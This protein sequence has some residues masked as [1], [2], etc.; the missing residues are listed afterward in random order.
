MNVTYSEPNEYND[1]FPSYI[2]T[3]KQHTSIKTV[4]DLGCNVG[5]F[6]KLTKKL[7]PD[8]QKIVGFEPDIDNF[9]Y[10]KAQNYT[11]VELHNVGIYYGVEESRVCG[12]GDNNIGGYMVS[13]IDEEHVKNWGSSILTYEGRVF[14][15]KPLEHFT[16]NESLDLIKIDVEA[17]EYNILDN[18]TD[19]QKFKWIIL[20][21]HN[22]N[23]DYYINYIKNTLPYHE[24]VANTDYHFLLKK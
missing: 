19:L 22:H 18:S 23:Y 16:E 20:E 21:C 13:T 1:L 17:S 4:F 8:V 24:I 15:L 3:I 9:N 10:I 14:K 2:E 12:V 6:I 11:D 5:A 7:L